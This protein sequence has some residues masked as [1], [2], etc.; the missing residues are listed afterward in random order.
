MQPRL[1]LLLALVAVLTTTKTT[2]AAPAPAPGSATGTQLTSIV[3][4]GDS[5]TDVGNVLRLTNGAWPLSPPNAYGRF[6]NGKM[7]PE[8]LAEA[9]ATAANGNDIDL[10][11]YAF[12]SA[13]SDSTL[14]PGYTG[15]SSNVSSPGVNKQIGMYESR[16]KAAMASGATPNATLFTV[17]AGGN[18][19][20]FDDPSFTRATPPAVAS[21][22]VR[23]VTQIEAIADKA[24]LPYYRIAV[25]NLPPLG[26]WPL[27]A[28]APAAGAMYTQLAAMIN[29]E[30]AVRLA[31]HNAEQYGVWPGQEVKGTRAVLTVDAATA[32]AGVL[33]NPAAYGFVSPSSPSS[34]AGKVTSLDAC[35]QTD[36][37]T[38]AVSVCADPASRVFW[39]SFH[40]TTRSHRLVASW[41]AA[42]IGIA[43][44]AQLP[45]VTAV[46]AVEGT[47][48][49]VT[50]VSSAA[51]GSI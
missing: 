13:T 35:V 48:T 45:A 27:F 51:V 28:R 6:S 10:Q 38:N 16:L 15:A 2:N 20:F 36:P 5:L 33:D 50:S 9:M 14:V 11:V 34:A 19:L 12:G 42:A 24:K 30:L 21:N 8:Y 49:A 32:V 44:P 23:A 37:D 18:D 47:S 43:F 22:L 1:T 25:I 4:F 41:V 7:W 46:P 31:T 39:D 3:A 40:P 26:R 17:F 29:G